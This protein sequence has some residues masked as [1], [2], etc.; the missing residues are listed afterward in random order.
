MKLLFRKQAPQQVDRRFCGRIQLHLFNVLNVSTICENYA[1]NR[2]IRSN[3][4][5][6]DDPVNWIAKE[7]KAGHQ[8]DIE[9]ASCELT[10]EHGRLVEHDRPGPAIDRKSVV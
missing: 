5:F 9:L 7:F 4:D 3:G 10:T 1:V 2:S 8:R 6:V